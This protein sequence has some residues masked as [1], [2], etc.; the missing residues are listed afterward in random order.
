MEKFKQIYG[1]YPKYPVADAGYG[2]CN[3]YLYCEEHGIEKYMKL[4]IFEKEKSLFSAFFKMQFLID[5]GAQKSMINTKIAKKLNIPII[6]TNIIIRTA[7]D[8]R[9]RLTQICRT[10]VFLG[11]FSSGETDLLIKV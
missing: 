3:N 5:T 8:Q 11:S 2:S 1:H 9:Y 10:E 6:D 7:T 4:T